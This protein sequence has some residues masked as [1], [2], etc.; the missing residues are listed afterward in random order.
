MRLSAHQK[1]N[2]EHLAD[3]WDDVRAKVGLEIRMGRASTEHL[4]IVDA[5]IRDVL[6]QE[7]KLDVPIRLLNE[8]MDEMENYRHSILTNVRRGQKRSI[9]I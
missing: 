2:I 8:V 5:H 6:I 4:T 7:Q 3:A 1:R 9:V